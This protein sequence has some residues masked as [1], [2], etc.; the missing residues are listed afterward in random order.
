MLPVRSVGNISSGASGSWSSNVYT[1]SKAGVW[2]VTATMGCLSDTALLTVTHNSP[3]NITVS[4]KNPAVIAGNTQAFAATANDLY[5]NTWDVSSS[6]IWFIDSGAVGSWLG[7]VY[8]SAKAGTWRITAVYSGFSDIAYLTV[9]YGPISAIAISPKTATLMAGSSQNFTATASDIYGN[10][11]AVSNSTVW[12][13]SS[14]A[15]GSWQNN[16]YTA[17]LTGQWTVTGSSLGVSGTASLTVTHASPVR[18]TVSLSSNSVIAGSNLVCTATATDSFGNAWDATASTVWVIDS[19]ASGTWNG[20]VYVS[21]KAGTWRVS[22]V[23]TGLSDSASVK[24]NPGLPISLTVSPK[25]V[26]LAAGSSQSYIATASDGFGNSWDVS[27]STVWSID[28]AAEGS[29]SGNVY[30]ASKA[31]TW[32]H[33]GQ[34]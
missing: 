32:H 7:N 26:N 21:A 31:G 27:G 23:Y 30:T 29:W 20:N 9:D 28:S 12:S 2:T 34:L 6:T 1:S 8:T 18:I 17:A 10:V 16:Q 11:W 19:G 22:G 24:V 4:P 13:I 3:V 33:N 14:G 5:G 15:G 25:T